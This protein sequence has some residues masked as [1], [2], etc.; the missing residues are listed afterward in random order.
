MYIIGTKL[1]K[2]IIE[3]TTKDGL[4]WEIF[5]KINAAEEMNPNAK[6]N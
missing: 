6:K 4:K 3:E 2:L 1:E 5:I